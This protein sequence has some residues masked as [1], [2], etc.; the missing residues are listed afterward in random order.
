RRGCGPARYGPVQKAGRRPAGRMARI[1]VVVDP[2][3][4][5][6]L[7]GPLSGSARRSPSQYAPC[8]PEIAARRAP[9]GSFHRSA[10]GGPRARQGSTV[11]E[12]ASAGAWRGRGGLPGRPRGL[13]NVL[14]VATAAVAAPW[15]GVA[16]IGAGASAAEQQ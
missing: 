9:V 2:P 6:V 5:S 11:P 8:D 12:P 7:D 10:H 3:G 1:G 14:A 15:V 4:Q 13:R 16:A